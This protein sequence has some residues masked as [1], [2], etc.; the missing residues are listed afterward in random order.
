VKK[1]GIKLEVCIAAVER[2]GVDESTLLPEITKV[3]NG[4]ISSIGYQ[5]K[6]YALIPNF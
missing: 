4:W 3:R 1:D 6:G 2:L 5:Q